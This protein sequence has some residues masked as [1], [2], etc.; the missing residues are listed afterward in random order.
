MSSSLLKSSTDLFSFSRSRKLKDLAVGKAAGEQT[1]PVRSS[2]FNQFLVYCRAIR[3]STDEK[4]GSTWLIHASS[5]LVR[6]TQCSFHIVSPIGSVAKGVLWS[7]Y[8]GHTCF[9]S[10]VMQQFTAWNIKK[11]TVRDS[12][13]NPFLQ[14]QVYCFAFLLSIAYRIFCKKFTRNVFILKF[15]SMYIEFFKKKKKKK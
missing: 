15:L 9:K 7:K 3:L 5:R 6:T 13:G 11:A 2:G 8:L 10:V 1:R 14:K 4:R 12:F